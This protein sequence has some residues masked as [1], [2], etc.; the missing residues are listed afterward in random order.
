MENVITL[1]RSFNSTNKQSDM[2]SIPYKQSVQGT[3]PFNINWDN[4]KP[5]ADFYYRKDGRPAIVSEESV[6]TDFRIKCTEEALYGKIISY[7]PRMDLIKTGK[8]SW[9]RQ[10][11]IK[12]EAFL[13]DYVSLLLNPSCKFDGDVFQLLV[14][15]KEARYSSRQRASA[16]VMQGDSSWCPDSWDVVVE[17]GLSSWTVWMRISANDLGLDK[18]T[19]GLAI[20]V[21][22]ERYRT[23]DG[24]TIY[25]ISPGTLAWTTQWTSELIHEAYKFLPAVIGKEPKGL[26]ERIEQNRKLYLSQTPGHDHTENVMGK[27]VLSQDSV[28]NINH[29]PFPLIMEKPFWVMM[30]P[31]YKL[32][33]IPENSGFRHLKTCHGHHWYVGGTY[34]Y[35]SAK[36]H[37]PRKVRACIRCISIKNKSGNIHLKDAKIQGGP[38]LINCEAVTDNDP[39]T[40]A[41][42]GSL[43]FAIQPCWISLKFPKALSI[44][45]VNID[46]GEPFGRT[47]WGE[48]VPFKNICSEMTLQYLNEDDT[49][50]TIENGHIKGCYKSSITFKFEELQTRALRIDINAVSYSGIQYEKGQEWKWFYEEATESSLHLSLPQKTEEVFCSPPTEEE[51]RK[52]P[53]CVEYLRYGSGGTFSVAVPEPGF[54]PALKRLKKINPE[55]FFGCLHHEWDSN[56]QILC[57]VS[58]WEDT[59]KVWEKNKSKLPPSPI[60]RIKSRKLWERLFKR[61]PGVKDNMAMPENSWR[62]GDH[63]AMDWG[64]PMPYIESTPNGS[65][66]MQTQIAFARGAARQFGTPWAQYLSLC[67]DQ[68]APNY[69]FGQTR[70]DISEQTWGRYPESGA[71][72]LLYKRMLMYSYFCGAGL[73]HLELSPDADLIPDNKFEN[74]EISPHGQIVADWLD[75]HHSFSERAVPYAPIAILLDVDH[76]YA[77][78]YQNCYAYGRSGYQTWIK[79]PYDE[80]DK[81]VAAFFNE[82]FPVVRQRIERDN[83]LM[84]NSHYGDLF[85]VIV[86]DL[87]SGKD[88]PH[89]LSSYQLVIALGNI[90]ASD[91]TI[92]Q[93]KECLNS[94]RAVLLNI[95]QIEVLTE[96]NASNGTKLTD[97]PS[98][99]AQTLHGGT[100]FIDHIPRMLSEDDS[101]DNKSRAFLHRLS[102]DLSPVQI[103]GNIQRA[104]AMRKEGIDIYLANNCGVFKHYNSAPEID[105]KADSIVFLHFNPDIAIRKIMIFNGTGQEKDLHLPDSNGN[106]KVVVRSGDAV[107]L[108]ALYLK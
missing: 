58:D 55:G 70:Y 39:K 8:T 2:L 28:N 21:N 34:Q 56:F 10:P 32:P 26:A 46:H 1:N 78:P 42:I 37:T 48:T 75:M 81:M 76:G 5:F 41:E 7:E 16:F 65:P 47:I 4:I 19:E 22:C 86:S 11:T 54:M 60:D 52:F 84:T 73:F 38:N 35:I 79:T 71:S 6:R 29:E 61:L 94:G 68:S 49:W 51:L 93:L 27:T 12:P 77:V 20:G 36:F 24:P 88:I 97:F 9:Q 45:E 106:L 31:Y 25:E 44:T 3:F 89:I 82:I 108:R 17:E 102:V 100:L 62:Q 72:W 18:L 13:D 104:F 64:A 66:S 74:F 40:F 67:L 83:F 98:I 92:A 53:G 57:T 101:I 69:F 33:G 96:I 80:D 103:T 99:T 90:K 14:N 43:G 59:G 85:D 30:P 107:I 105:K 91:R 87:E 23:P 15:S 50:E 95:S 63:Y